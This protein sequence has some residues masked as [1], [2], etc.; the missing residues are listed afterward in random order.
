MCSKLIVDAVQKKNNAARAP[1]LDALQG[2]QGTG[3]MGLG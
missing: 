3:V 2:C 1:E